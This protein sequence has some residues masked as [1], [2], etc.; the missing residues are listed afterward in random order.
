MGSFLVMGIL[1]SLF[2]LGGCEESTPPSQEQSKHVYVTAQLNHL[3][4]PIERGERYEDPLDEALSQKGLGKVDGGGTMQLQSGEIEHIDVE[5]ILNNPAEGISFVI[6][7]MT[8]GLMVAVL[9]LFSNV[10][11]RLA[12]TFL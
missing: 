2:G 6:E 3:L 10:F 5:V 12:H 8:I 7:H 11:L 4:M 9:M 1:S